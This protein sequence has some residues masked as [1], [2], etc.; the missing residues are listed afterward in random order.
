M[1]SLRSLLVVAITLTP[2][3]AVADIVGLSIG[4]GSLAGKPGR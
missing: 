2:L 1:I 3:T 4:G